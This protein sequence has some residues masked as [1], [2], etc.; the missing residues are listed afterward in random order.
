MI[1]PFCEKEMTPD[2]V[3]DGSETMLRQNCPRCSRCV[4]H[5]PKPKQA[6]EMMLT[7]G[8]HKGKRIG[9]VPEKY[10]QWLVENADGMNRD[11]RVAIIEHLEIRNA[12]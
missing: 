1:C 5:T 12:S 6:A 10:L 2:T 4:G 3:D 11:L 9:A 8:K 7:F